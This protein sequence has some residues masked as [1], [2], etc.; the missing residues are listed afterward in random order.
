MLYQIRLHPT[1]IIFIKSLPPLHSLYFLVYLIYNKNII[2][3]GEALERLSPATSTVR[4]MV[5]KNLCYSED[6][7]F[8][9]VR[10]RVVFSFS[11]N[12]FLKKCALIARTMPF[13]TSL[14]NSRNDSM[15]I[16]SFPKDGKRSDNHTTLTIFGC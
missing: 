4:V 2:K 14:R 8:C 5:V 7:P 1:L 16:T 15:I 13:K 12:V 9:F 3:K 10:R 11:R 6:P